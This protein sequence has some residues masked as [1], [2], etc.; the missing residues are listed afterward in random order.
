MFLKVEGEPEQGSNWQFQHAPW[1]HNFDR[2]FLFSI[3]W[4]L[5]Y[6]LFI[7]FLAQRAT[8]KSLSNL[9]NQPK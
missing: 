2:I 6:K 9:E 7:S 8:W 1:K 4:E 3:L 5:F